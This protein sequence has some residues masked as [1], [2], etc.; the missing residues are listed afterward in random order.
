M[1][2]R[3]YDGDS[4]VLSFDA[5]VLRVEGDGTRVELDRSAFY[6]TGGGQ[7][8]DT[9]TLDGVRVLDVVDEDTRVIHVLE[10]AL[11]TAHTRVVGHVDAE[12]RRDHMQQHTAQHLLSA[13]LEDYHGR[14]TVSFHLGAELSTIDL[15]GAPLEPSHFAAIERRVFDAITADLAVRASVSDTPKAE[16]RKPTD[17]LGPVR[18]VTIEGVDLNA[19]GGTHVRSTGQL[20]LVLLVGVEKVR[21]VTRLS[22]AAGHRALARSRDDAN[23]LAELAAAFGTAPRQ[24]IASA[25]K[26]RGLLAAAEKALRV[27]HAELAARDGQA[28]YAAT[29]ADAAGRRLLCLAQEAPLDDRLRATAQAFVAGARA[30]AMIT[31][32]TACTILLAASPDSGIDAGHVL[33][34]ILAAHGGKGGGSATLAQGSLPDAS[35]FGRATRAVSD[36]IGA[37]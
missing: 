1:T 15:D 31:S 16:L 10:R 33:K 26:Q 14:Q 30:V 20:G 9:G 32:E 22:F 5:E 7:P 19:C 28:R 12:R 37:R 11:D 34:P 25:V 8:H 24:A 18:V 17:R 23:L 36:A 29:A 27:A 4:F 13:I 2:E 21:S 3:L 6:P 35:A